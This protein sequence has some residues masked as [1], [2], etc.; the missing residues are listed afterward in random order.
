MRGRFP[1]GYVTSTTPN[2]RSAFANSSN[3]LGDDAGAETG[4]LTQNQIPG[5]THTATTTVTLATTDPRDS[6]SDQA[7]EDADGVVSTEETPIAISETAH[8]HTYLLGDLSVGSGSPY[9]A[10][11]NV[12]STITRTT[13]SA[14]TGITATTPAHGHDIPDM[15]HNHLATAATTNAETGGGNSHA[16][17]PPHFVVNFVILAKIPQAT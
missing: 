1:L 10:E 4:I 12:A 6:T 13:A 8:S 17:M 2:G 15:T 11:R 16:L 14:T 3:S 7:N 5:H 9:Y